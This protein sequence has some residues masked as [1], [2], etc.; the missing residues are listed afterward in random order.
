MIALL[1]L[2]FAGQLHFYEELNLFLVFRWKH[3]EFLE[4]TGVQGK[5][6]AGGCYF[7]RRRHA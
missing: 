1:S 5:Y 3:L 4:K 7:M 2:F 6:V